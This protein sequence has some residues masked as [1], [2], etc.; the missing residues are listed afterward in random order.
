MNRKKS[1]GLDFPVRT[2]VGC[3]KAKPKS[4][5]MRFVSKGGELISDIKGIMPGRGVYLCRDE[6]CFD[7][8]LKTKAFARGLRT[9]VKEESIRETLE[10]A[11]EMMKNA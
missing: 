4:E 1:K 8:A 6:E 7:K 2:C 10:T 9:S 11:R 3:R 5:M